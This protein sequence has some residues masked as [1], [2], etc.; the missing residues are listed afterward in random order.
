MNNSK[1][2]CLAALAL[3]VMAA[4]ALAHHGT[5]GSYD[6]NKTV[7]VDGVVKEFRWRNPHSALFVVAKDAAGKEQT[8]AIEMGSPNALSRSGMIRT[9]IKPGDKVVVE[10]H[11]SFTNPINGY[12]LGGSLKMTVNGKPVRMGGQQQA[13]P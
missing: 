12:T 8:Y 13:T 10:M 1:I 7:T 9:S 6:D 11:P 3:G 5:S 2:A 4:P